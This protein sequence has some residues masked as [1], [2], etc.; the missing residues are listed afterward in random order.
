MPT[1]RRP[2][3]TA[4]ARLLAL[5]AVA[6]PVAVRAQAASGPTGFEVGGLP[7][8]AFDSDEGFG[9]GAFAQ[10]YDYGDGEYAPYRWSL[11]PTLYNTSKGRLE[12]YA[13][14]DA[15]HLLPG[16]WRLNGWVGY[17]RFVATPYY[18]LGNDAP[19]DPTLDAED[20]PNPYWYRFGRTRAAARFTL[21]YGIS[22]TPWR[23]L[24]GVGIEDVD[25]DPLP[26]DEGTTLFAQEFGAASTGYGSSFLRAGLVRDTR[27]R[28]TGTRTGSWSEFLVWW[29][30]ESLASHFSAVRWTLTDRRYCTLAEG[31]VLAHRMALQGVDDG[32]PL[33]ELTRLQTSFQQQEGLGG[34]K[35][36]RGVLRNR[37]TGRGMFVW[38]SELRWRAAD[39]AALGRSFHAVLSAYLDQGRVWAGGVR[40]DDIFSDLH[41]GYGG[42]LRVG[43]GEN[44]V[45]AFDG[46]TSSETGLQ[47]YLGLGY[48]Y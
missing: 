21:Q 6:S 37:Y 44:F 19:Y 43:M 29:S 39:F 1:T 48:L 27:D 30:D 5:V 17:E 41:R 7:V 12:A 36:V 34:A 25:V 13:F 38:N 10:L 24:L 42:G 20:G 45:V 15:P 8:A 32:A 23:L 40:A 35:T 11:Q 46:G 16:G 9:Y 2:V 47:I 14:F 26:R 22:S 31:L 33:P 4:T 18:G 28:E 3:L